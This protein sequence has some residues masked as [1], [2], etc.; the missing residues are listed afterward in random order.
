MVKL[1][2]PL[3]GVGDFLD[4]LA[5]DIVDL[6]GPAIGELLKPISDALAGVASAVWNALPDQIK[7]VLK[8]L[9]ELAGKAWDTLWAFI[10]DPVGTLAPLAQKVIDLL[11]APLQDF[12][13]WLG[14]LGKGLWTG[15]NNFIKDPV[16]TLKKGWDS[17]SSGIATAVSDIGAGVSSAVGGAVDTIKTAFDGAVATAT[18]WVSDALAGVAKALGDAL[19]GFADW[20]IGGLKSLASTL[21]GGLKGVMDAVGDIIRPIVVGFIDTLKAAFTPG[22]PD[23]ELAKSVNDMVKKTQ[24]RI[25]EELKKAY[26]S[27]FDPTQAIVTSGVISALVLAGQVMVHT[28]ASAAGVSVLGTRLDL[29]DVVESAVDTMGLNRVV[30]SSFALPIEI[31]ML[32]PLR[33]A[34]NQMFT[35]AIP[36]PGDLI[37]FVVREVIDVNVF[38]TNLAYQ[39]FSA[40]W[41]DAFWEA[42]W[43]LPA[44]GEIVDAFHRGVVSLDELS[45][46]LVWL[47]YKPEPRPGIS[48]SDLEILRGIQKT[49]IGRV[50][51]R[52]GY[53]LGGLTKADLVERFRWLGYEDDAELIA[54]IQIRAALDAEIG[55]VRDNAKTDLVKG[56][57]LEADLRSTLKEL[58]YGADVIEFHVQ[59]ALQ[60]RERARKDLQVSTL[61]DAYV[62]EEIKTE[63][64]LAALLAEYIVDPELIDAM[65]TDAYVRRYKKPKAGAAA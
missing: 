51:L 50:D 16:G 49:P 11:P 9:G 59:D 36:G 53:E 17:I 32:Q 15:L 14:E 7:S 5:Q 27:P 44:R 56:Y 30:G 21:A 18:G 45:K 48:K 31:G 41:A 52:R 37:R 65:V 25:L 40:F 10:K 63:D 58:G 39:G 24:E 54:E 43:M 13:K 60:D 35:P 1:G 8:F 19:G 64:E 6:V 42:H 12:I 26:K 55:K 46:F 57:I 47:D 61:Q 23:K 62:K 2:W 38:R 3:E 4:G 22:S 29:T 20:F 33:Y 34:Y 28:L